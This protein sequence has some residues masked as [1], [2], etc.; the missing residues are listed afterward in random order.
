MKNKIIIV[1]LLCLNCG[2][3]Y[4]QKR[5][6]EGSG[7]VITKNFNL[8]A[9]KKISFEDFDGQ[10]EVEMGKPYSISVQIDENLAPRLEVFKEQKEELTFKLKGNYNGKLYLEN[11]RIKIKVTVP[12]ATEIFHRGNTSLHISGILGRYFKLEN[13]GNG[14]AVLTGNI[15][16]LEIKKRGN[17]EVK[18]QKLLC[19]IANVKSFGNGNVAINSLISLTATGSGNCSVMQFG[20]GKIEPLSGIVGNGEVRKM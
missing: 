4:T 17:G 18:A 1:A 16:E 12:E 7:K 15:D 8:N 2:L 14:N 19:K 3:L 13:N 20:P 5:P 9:F 10:I 11:T 6:L